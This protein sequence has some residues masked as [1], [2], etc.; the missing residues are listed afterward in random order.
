[1]ILDVGPVLGIADLFVLAS[2][3]NERQLATV[4][5]EVQLR[6]KRELGRRVV[7]REGEPASGW[8][9]L[10]FGDVLVHVF[11]TERREYYQLER[12]WSDAPRIP[13]TPP[14]PAGAAAGGAGARW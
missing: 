12:L 8:V 3:R 2:A 5:E 14:V 11:D 9:I 13:F 10:D 7:R 6:C 4:V 1:M